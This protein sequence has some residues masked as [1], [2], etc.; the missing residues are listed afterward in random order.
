MLQLLQ[1]PRL[2]S[3]L[4]ALVRLN[5]RSNVHLSRRYK[6]DLTG[7]PF[8]V[9]RSE[10]NEKMVKHRGF[11]EA[12]ND[13]SAS[14]ALSISKGDPVK[15][16][17][18]PFHSASINVHSSFA[19]QYGMDRTEYYWTSETY[20]DGSGTIQTRMVQQSR[21][22]TDWY[23][24]SGTLSSAYYPLGTLSTQIYAGFEFPRTVI[25]TA[26]QTHLVAQCKPLTQEMLQ[27][28]GTKKTVYP[29]E[30]NMAYA[31][32]KLFSRVH[33]LEHHRAE[34]YIPRHF[35]ADHARIDS[36]DV[37]FDQAEIELFS[38]H[39]PAY[40]YSTTVNDLLRYKVV[41]G[42]SG[43]IHGN[44][45]Y[46]VLKS[47]LFGAGV[48]SILTYAFT[49]VTRPFLLVPQ[50]LFRV[51]L[52]A[53]T[54]GLLSGSMAKLFNTRQESN[55]TSTT[56]SEL[57]SNAHFEMSDED[58]QRRKLA[59]E[60]NAGS[61]YRV[62]KRNLSLPVDK[63][64]ILGLNPENDISLEMVKEAYHMQI[65]KWHPDFFGSRDA[66]S[67]KIAEAIS[68]Q[69]NDAHKGLSDILRTNQPR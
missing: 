66:N 69:L 28:G 65:K 3:R 35:N 42:H 27:F 58:I 24:C 68:K 56:K 67:K 64:K 29:H 18:V 13:G 53:S 63:C 47:S 10:A 62:N 8:K 34:Q 41:N 33:D 23:R 43:D 55:F 19:G 30:M 36:L 17:F 57:D 59:A 51:V 2:E 40:I 9:T 32:E 12:S 22:V 46:S 39:V 11:L 38:Y 50:V 1:S 31:L 52:G 20:P 26:L 4:L 44:K 60:M 48:G 49:A 61:D 14:T 5:T 45:I 37:H 6:S 54:S 21:I 15:E 25:E 16:C 7:L